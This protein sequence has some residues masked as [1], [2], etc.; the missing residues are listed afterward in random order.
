MKRV[1][2]LRARR[3]VGSGRRVS[4]GET[5]DQRIGW[6]DVFGGVCDFCNLTERE[7]EGRNILRG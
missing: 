2:R 1:Q 3:M 4:L 6:K 7:H 5:G